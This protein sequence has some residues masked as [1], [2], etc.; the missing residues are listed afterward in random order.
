MYSVFL[1]LLQQRGVTVA[2]VCRETGIN[3][4]TLSNWKARGN[5]LSAKNAE[6]IAKY[7]NVSVD[8]LMTG[9][10]TPTEPLSD[11]ERELLRLFRKLNATGQSDALRRISE[12]IQ[13]G[14]T[15][16]KKGLSSDSDEVTA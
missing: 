5:K 8:Y 4:S 13:L 16:D 12:L 11:S 6:L 3:Q 7:F 14:Y 9:A 2:D 15:A 1:E 10:R